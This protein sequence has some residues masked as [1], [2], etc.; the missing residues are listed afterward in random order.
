MTSRN[1]GYTVL[2]VII[3]LSGCIGVDEVISPTH[4]ESREYI[5][6]LELEYALWEELKPDSTL[7][8]LVVPNP[9]YLRYSLE[10][11]MDV[12]NDLQIIRDAKYIDKFRV[13]SHFAGTMCG[14]VIFILPGGAFGIVYYVNRCV[15]CCENNQ[16]SDNVFYDGQTVWTINP[17]T[18]E[19]YRFDTECCSPYNITFL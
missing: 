6:R 13:C 18:M 2:L 10:E 16:H 11:V 14:D 5:G 7:C 1:A 8:K 19:V 17:L 12:V 3:V 9:H 15:P 4:L